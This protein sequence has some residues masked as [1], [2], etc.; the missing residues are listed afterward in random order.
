MRPSAGASGPN[1]LMM[2]RRRKLRRITLQ[3][4]EKK[5]GQTV[6][7]SVTVF[8]R[9]MCCVHTQCIAQYLL[10]LWMVFTA[11]RIQTECVWCA[12]VDLMSD[13]EDGLVHRCLGGCATSAVPAWSSAALCQ[14]TVKAGG[15]SEEQAPQHR[16]LH[17]PSSD[18]TPPSAH[19]SEAE[20]RHMRICRIRLQYSTEA[21]APHRT[22]FCSYLCITSCTYL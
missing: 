15:R 9:Y 3:P 22:V 10:S 13:G 19:S 14:A 1:S 6:Y 12:A 4:L 2:R 17:G 11:V 8:Y 5:E 21:C 18:R 16:G 20:S 7:V